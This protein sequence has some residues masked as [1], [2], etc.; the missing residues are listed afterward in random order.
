VRALGVID[1]PTIQKKL[2]LHFTL[3]L[4]LFGS[5]VSTNAANFY[6]NGLKGR[7]HETRIDD[8]HRLTN[9]TYPVSKL[10]D[11]QVKLMDEPALTALNMRLRDD[12]VRDCAKGVERW[13]KVIEKAGA[14]FRLQLPHV[15]FHREIGE[16]AKVK[17]TPDGKVI[18]EATFEKSKDR[19][20]PSTADGDFIASL[21][22]PQMEP[23]RFASWIAPPKVGIDNKPGDFEYVKIAA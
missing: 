7:F 20:L 11:G 16:F 4:D 22:E 3:S 19:W 6:N 12:Y 23:A 5:E 9:A 18:D 17:V 8:D 10:V 13:N 1:L 2:N 14:K 15:A 21:M